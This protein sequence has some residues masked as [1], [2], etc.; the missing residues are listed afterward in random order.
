VFVPGLWEIGVFRSV[1]S[2]VSSHMIYGLSFQCEGGGV[3][4]KGSKVC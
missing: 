2:F 1:Q 3:E 4:S